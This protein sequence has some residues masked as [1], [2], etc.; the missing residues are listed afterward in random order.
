[1]VNAEAFRALVEEHAPWGTGVSSVE[2]ARTGGR[3]V[4]TVTADNPTLFIG[5]DGSRLRAVRRTVRQL[6]GD[7]TARVT[8]K[9]A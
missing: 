5:S 4:V 8:V 9:A 6:T 3:L 7:D 2:V 1:V